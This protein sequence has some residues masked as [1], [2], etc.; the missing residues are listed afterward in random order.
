MIYNPIYQKFHCLVNSH[1]IPKNQ[2][3]SSELLLKLR[4]NFNKLSDTNPKNP[5]KESHTNRETMMPMRHFTYKI[6]IGS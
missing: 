4:S 3:K 1:L 6:E 5:T 2:T